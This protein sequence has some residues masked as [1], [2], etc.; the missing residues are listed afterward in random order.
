M[1]EFHPVPRRLSDTP[2]TRCFGLECYAT[3]WGRGVA[4]P[5]ACKAARP[6]SLEEERLLLLARP[7]V[8]DHDALDVAGAER[9]RV[10]AL[11]VDPPV[12]KSQ[13]KSTDL[14][15]VLQDYNGKVEMS[16]RRPVSLILFSRLKHTL[17]ALSKRRLT[18]GTG[19]QYALFFVCNLTKRIKKYI[20]INLK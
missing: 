3:A 17:F 5:V 6:G 15:R 8:D 12:R 18:H 4:T 19:S 9:R 1:C 11:E 13:F 14:D 2:N 16:L 20:A 10:D 7:V